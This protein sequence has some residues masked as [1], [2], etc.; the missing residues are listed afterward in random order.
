MEG[1]GGVGFW[2]DA[3][4]GDS[5]IVKTDTHC[6]EPCI[7][8]NLCTHWNPG[9]KACDLSQLIRVH[10][11]RSKP[12]PLDLLKP[13]I[14]TVPTLSSHPCL[15]WIILRRNLSLKILQPP[16][17]RQPCHDILAHPRNI[18]EEEDGKNAGGDAETCCD[19]AA[20]EF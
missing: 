9:S 20:V 17:H 7:A 11:Y 1:D 8:V 6:I 15:E 5:T 4:C 14:Y 19:R 13:H 12:R 2:I 3:G 10:P 16:N 18:P